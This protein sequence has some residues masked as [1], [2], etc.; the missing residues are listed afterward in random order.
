MSSNGG[1]TVGAVVRLSSSPGT[2]ERIID[3][4]NG[5]GNSNIIL[6]RSGTSSDL[7]FDVCREALI[8]VL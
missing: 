6:A 1:F 5:S 3:F 7:V 8:L 4:G 2:G